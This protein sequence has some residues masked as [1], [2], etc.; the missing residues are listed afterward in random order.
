M[1]DNDQMVTRNISL[2]VLGFAMVAV[3]AFTAVEQASA[4]SRGAGVWEYK[5]LPNTHYLSADDMQ[6]HEQMLNQMGAQ[7]WEL[8]LAPGADNYYYFKR[9]K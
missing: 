5:L 9:P 1:R 7:G 4:K 8:V 2:A 6:M 3:F